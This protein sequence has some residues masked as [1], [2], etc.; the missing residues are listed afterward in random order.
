[1]IGIL[2]KNIVKILTLYAISPGSRFNREEM[3]KKSRMNN[4]SLNKTLFILLN[5]KILLKEK[6]FFSL[7]FE[8]KETSI[9]LELVSKQYSTL[10]HLPLLSYYLIL[11]I[12]YSF[13]EQEVDGEIYLF[14]SYAKLS[15]KESSDIDIAI[16]SD[17]L[18]KKIFNSLI[19]KVEKKF[20]KD[21]EV[22]YFSKSF[23]KNKRD[24]LVKE[25]LQHGVKLI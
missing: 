9:L 19:S 1:M 12:Y 8:N 11:E 24:P 25:I 23:Y 17:T 14:G 20:G 5:L 7:N 21:I 10:K 6:H 3:K 22:H 15:F 18:D 16:I 4:I 2:E 13:I